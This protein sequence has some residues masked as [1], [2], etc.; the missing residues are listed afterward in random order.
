MRLIDSIYRDLSTI[1]QRANA[2]GHR[3][4]IVG[5][6]NARIGAMTGDHARN[7]MGRDRFLP[8]VEQH[9]LRILNLDD[10]M[11]VKTSLNSNDSEGVPRQS[12]IVSSTTLSSGTEF[13]RRK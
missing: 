3:F 13:M 10:H 6:W 12:T 1:I 9:Q 5:D 7:P 8:F 4:M 11:S 2:M